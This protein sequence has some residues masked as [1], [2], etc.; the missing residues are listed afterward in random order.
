MRRPGLSVAAKTVYA[1][2]ATYADRNGWI[3][4]RQETVAADLERSRTW[5][6]AAVAELEGQGLL[7]HDRQYVEGRQRASRYRLLDGL[8]RGTGAAEAASADADSAVRP[9]DTTHHEE[10]SGLS[11]PAAAC[12]EE[13]GDDPAARGEPILPPP[14]WMPTPEDTAWALSRHPQLDVLSFTENFILSCR[15]RGYRYADLS[16]AWRRWLLEPK[17]RLPT[18]RPAGDF[19]HDRPA[20]DCEPFIRRPAA[21]NGFRSDRSHSPKLSAGEA[22][23]AAWGRAVARRQAARAHA[24]GR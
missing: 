21:G 20:E 19:R 14:D 6:H 3:W 1:S 15:A 8:T 10:D 5:V 24:D 11:L 7:R 18:I 12:A 22:R 16:A 9:T 13:G 2:L 4:V 23:V 17:G